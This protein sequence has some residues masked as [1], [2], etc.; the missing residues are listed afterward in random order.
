MTGRVCAAKCL[1]YLLAIQKYNDLIVVCA[2]E[3]DEAIDAFIAMNTENEARFRQ[4]HE[5][6]VL[7][8]EQAGL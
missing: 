4:W 1:G 3:N 6:Y 7:P 8:L 2:I 5:E